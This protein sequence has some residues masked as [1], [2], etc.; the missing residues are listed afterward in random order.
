MSVN[1]DHNVRILES[2]GFSENY[3][4]AVRDHEL[5]DIEGTRSANLTDVI[6]V[7]NLL[8]NQQRAEPRDQVNLN[9]VPACRRLKLHVGISVE[10]IRVSEMEIRALH[11]IIGI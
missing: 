8:A 7:A 3:V 1:P 2:W 9:K 6:F 4:A 5:C 10:I 11:K